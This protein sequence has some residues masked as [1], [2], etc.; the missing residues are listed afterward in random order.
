MKKKQ[1]ALLL[2]MVLI[3]SLLTGCGGG[4]TMEGGADMAPGESYDKFQESA[5][6]AIF[7]D[8]IYESETVKD[9][10]SSVTRPYGD[11]VKLILRA[12]LHLETTDFEDAVTKL[13]K[14]VSDC[15]GY[16][17]QSDVDMGSYYS[18]GY[19]YGRYTVRV[20]KDK[21]DTFLNSVGEVCHVTSRNE[22]AEDVGLQYYDIESRIRLLE[23]KQ[24]R[25]MSL[26]EQASTM[27]DIIT[28]ENALSDIQY[29]LESNNIQKNRY[30]SLIDY[31][32]ISIRLEQVQRLSGEP[33]EQ[34]SFFSQLSSAFSRGFLNAVDGFA[35]LLLTLAYNIIPL[36]IFAVIVIVFAS[37]LKKRSRN[38]N[39]NGPNQK[40]PWFRKKDQTVGDIRNGGDFIP[41]SS[42]DPV[43]RK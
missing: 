28:L 20:P 6:G 40:K 17:E 31:S 36:T 13:N 41:P 8:Q 30:D 43:D 42:E 21:Y 19:R 22:S 25:L 24:E 32:T 14:L 12:D 23:I 34:Q 9:S 18:D 35:D 15:G 10:S 39:I 4:A 27:E 5:N 29:Q 38:R 3:L 37:F 16:Y 7:D 33:L 11:D 2:A 26:L 1:T